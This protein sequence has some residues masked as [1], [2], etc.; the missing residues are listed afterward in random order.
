MPGLLCLVCA[1]ACEPAFSKDFGGTFGLGRVEYVGCPDC[2]TCVSKTHYELP[3]E[4]WGALN[5]RYHQQ[6]FG[7]SAN[8]DDARWM[9]RLGEQAAVFSELQKQGVLPKGPVLDWGCGDGQ[10][11]DRLTAAGVRCEKF[12]RYVKP[13]GGLLEPALV[14]GSFGVV[15]N[16][17]V[18]EHVRERRT[19]DEIAGLVSADGIVAMHTIICEVVPRDPSWFYLLPVHCT[20]LTNEAMRRLCAEWGFVATL[21]DVPARLWLL[22]RNLPQARRAFDALQP[23]RTAIHFKE[24]FI[25][26]W[27]G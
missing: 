24:G 4:A 10:L 15:L 14:A 12:D 3:S 6:Y 1:R 11:A 17:S 19:L 9:E 18:V 5:E 7:S 13:P 8:A 16:T 22:F 2:G 25:D 21:Y 23:T 26:F 20:F 27:K